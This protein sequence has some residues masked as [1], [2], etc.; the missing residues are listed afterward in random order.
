MP[1]AE[2]N[3]ASVCS[4]LLVSEATSSTDGGEPGWGDGSSRPTGSAGTLQGEAVLA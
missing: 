3:A 1:G 4:G 2:L